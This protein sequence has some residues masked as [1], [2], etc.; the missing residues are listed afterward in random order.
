MN[1]PFSMAKLSTKN[2]PWE[3]DPLLW[4]FLRRPVATPLAVCEVKGVGGGCW[5]GWGKRFSKVPP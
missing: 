1:S 4:S 3:S 5:R 2:D